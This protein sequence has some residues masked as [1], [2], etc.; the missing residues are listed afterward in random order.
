MAR[1]MA[2][3]ADKVL[4]AAMKLPGLDHLRKAHQVQTDD[5]DSLRTFLAA[6]AENRKT[7]VQVRPCCVYSSASI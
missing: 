3:V 7:A 4:D 2:E 6:A 5:S 1:E